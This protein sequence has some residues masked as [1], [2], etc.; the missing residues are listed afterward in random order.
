VLFAYVHYQ[1]IVFCQFKCWAVANRRSDSCHVTQ[2]S[3]INTSKILVSVWKIASVYSTARRQNECCKNHKDTSLIYHFL[4]YGESSISLTQPAAVSK[5]KTR[6]VILSNV[7]I[8]GTDII[9][10]HLHRNLNSS[11]LQFE[12]AYWPALALGGA[13][14]LAAAHCWTPSSSTD[15]PM[16]QPAALMAFTPQCS[17]AM[18]HYF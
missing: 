12:V 8:K 15:P 17:P 9:H 4:N 3:S 5:I 2:P 6:L 7:K 10:R 11:R 14:Q 16:P 18:T 1:Q 13:A